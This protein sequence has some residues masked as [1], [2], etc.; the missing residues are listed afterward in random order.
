MRALLPGV[1]LLLGV[2][3]ATEAMAQAPL[4]AVQEHDLLPR[5]SFQECALCPVMV[6]VPEGT[7]AMGSPAD[8]KPR[9]AN[10][11]PQHQVRIGA[12]FAL[13]K[14]EVSVGQFAAFIADTGYATGDACDVWRDGKFAE[15]PGYSW[16][17]PGFAQS[18]A[19]P[20]ACAS[21]DDAKAYAAW[22][23]RKTGKAYRLPSEAEWEYAARA[24][25]TTRFHFGDDI[26]DYC[27]YGNG[28][29][30][31]AAAGV[32]G[33]DGWTVLPCSDG[34]PYTAPIGSFGP[35]AFGLYDTLG[36]V[37]EWVE[38][39]WHDGYTGAPADGSAW[40][41][42]DCKVRVQRGGAWGY[43]PDYLRTAVRG[44]QG[45]GYR[46]VNAG[47]RIARMLAP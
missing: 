17:N 33:A 47:M 39:C 28:A 6:V 2:A 8:E 15:R 35:N 11:G 7:F 45:Q 44:R 23:S 27:R 5:A 1:W 12:R 34:H 20:V 3:M 24:G 29:D 41:T 42:G 31:A 14:F 43:P 30:K 13:G 16:R 38:D 10:E 4:T 40:T 36:N 9:D 19:H 25:T 22:L 26:S 18:P 32:P 21:W 37:F 46:Y